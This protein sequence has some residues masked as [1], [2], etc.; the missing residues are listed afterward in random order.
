MM[1]IENQIVELELKK[2]FS[3]VDNEQEYYMPRC[4]VD[5]IWHEKLKDTDSYKEFCL[6][7]SKAYIE[8]VENKGEGVIPW[9]PKYE[10]RFGK[11]PPSWFT[12]YDG[13]VVTDLYD[14]Y[15]EE[16]N[17]KLEWDCKPIMTTD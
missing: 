13:D 2:F 16:G 3:L 11:L 4:I 5:K 1:G 14:K 10:K 6:K 7:Y 8:H 17:I 15:I 12:D 9:I